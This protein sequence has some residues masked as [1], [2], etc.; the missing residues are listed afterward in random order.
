LGFSVAEQVEGR[1][2]MQWQPHPTQPS[3]LHRRKG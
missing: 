2:M 1:W 3:W